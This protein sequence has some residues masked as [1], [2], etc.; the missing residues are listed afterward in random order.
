[1]TELTSGWRSFLS[2][3]AFFEA[4]QHVVGARRWLK[5]FVRETLKPQKG[6][7]MLDIG[8]GPAAI[9]HYLPDIEY[10]GFDHSEAYILA[11]REKYGKRAKFFC[12]DVIAVGKYGLPSFSIVTAVGVLHHIDD[13]SVLR[14]FAETREA[15]APRGRF[16]TADPCFF[17]GMPWITRAII[18]NDRGGEYTTC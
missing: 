16:I 4:A 8:C 6:D 13:A 3:P 15:L 18:S 10:C 14:L 12:D 9:L 11:A 1:M 17:D 2:H 7:R 5:R